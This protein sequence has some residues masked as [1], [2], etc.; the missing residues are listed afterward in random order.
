MDWREV[1]QQ[2]DMIGSC[3]HISDIG[4]SPTLTV[5]IV[6]HDWDIVARRY[7]DLKRY[8]YIFRDGSIAYGS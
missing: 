6:F 7:L 2:I 5:V 3:H 4:I 1:Y 8:C